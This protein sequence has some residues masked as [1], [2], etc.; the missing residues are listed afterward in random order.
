MR[1]KKIILFSDSVATLFLGLLLYLL[2]NRNAYVSTVLLRVISV[3]E[4]SSENFL[5]KLLRGYGADL[6]WSSSF[7]LIIQIIVWFPKK[8]L[9]LLLFCSLLGVLYELLQYVGLVTGIA[10][11]GDVIVY[12]FGSLLALSI[13]LGG[14][15]YEEKTVSS[16]IYGS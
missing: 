12:I 9:P 2:F 5:I 10:D 16:S 7:T 1:K 15:Y 8:K 14:K 13:I 4:I 6:F 3:P 11:I